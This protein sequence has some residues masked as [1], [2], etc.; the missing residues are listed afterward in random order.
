MK[1]VFEYLYRDAGNFKNYGDAQ[2]R[3]DTALPLD[4]IDERIRAALIDGMYFSAETLGLPTLYFDESN[5][6]LDHEWHEFDCVREVDED[7]NTPELDILAVIER[8][9]VGV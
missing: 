6:E 9:A 5:D 8:L 3:N 1:I 4:E 2:F 7:E